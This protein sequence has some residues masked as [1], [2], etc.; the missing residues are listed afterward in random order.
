MTA[1]PWWRSAVI[2]QVYPRSF[3][4]TD[5]DGLGDLPGVIDR[6]DYLA[7]L[8]VDAVWLSPCYVS[9]LHDGGY[10]VAD[11]RA[12]DPRLGDLDV[13]RALI[14]QAHARGIRVFMDLVPNH[15]SSEHAWFQEALASEPGS[16]AWDRYILRPGKG[17]RGELPP[18]NW[19]SVFHGAGW[20]PVPDQAGQPTGNW[21]LHLFDSTQ[22]DL[23]W[24]NPQVRAEFDAILRFWF[25]FG[26]DGFRI[27][28]AHGLVKAPGLPDREAH[29]LNHH[30]GP[31]WDQDGVHE[32]YRR[33][34]AIADSYADPRVF[35]G[36]AWTPSEERLALYLRP[37]EL[38]T[39]FN[40]QYLDA[41]WDIERMRDVIDTT[42]LTHEGVGAAPTWVLSNHDVVRHRTRMAPLHEDGTPDL[43]RGLARARAAT[44]FAFALP[45]SMYVY[46][47]EELGLPEVTD[48][49][50]EV[51]QDP[52]WFRS[53]GEDGFRDGSRV[54][55]P[56]T[57]AGDSYGF[58]PTGASWLPQPDDWAPLSVQAQ[59]GVAESTLELYR[60]AL[61]AR[62]A[63]PALGDGPLE[64]AEELADEVHALA[65]RRPS[66]QGPGVLAVLNM[67]E[68]PLALPASLGTEVLVE[69]GDQVAVLSDGDAEHLVIGP[70]TTVWLRA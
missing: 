69:S 56:W 29:P 5:G 9:P 55:L 59:D 64:W 12:I 31:F 30:V 36:E 58:S 62:R 42:L 38:H 3:Q 67:G 47:G 32:V 45:G 53:K 14:E 6:L 18:N 51:R 66:E 54:P 37:D 13:M 28:V 41:G 22:P 44:L 70:E 68:R 2:Y 27:D 7:S 11:Y 50:D 65:F 52:A 8:S 34:R 48:L 39:C 33:W 61:A 57:T 25:D 40:F 21:Y 46:Q 43:V 49:A 16:P 35:C 23:N 17:P 63:E 1:G 19:R 60:R 10:D 26:I 15:S 20:S 4:D 24:E